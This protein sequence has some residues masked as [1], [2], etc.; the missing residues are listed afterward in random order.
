MCNLILIGSFKVCSKII[1]WIFKALFS[2]QDP[3]TGFRC[4][5]TTTTVSATSDDGS[6]SLTCS[7]TSGICTGSIMEEVTY[8][9]TVGFTSDLPQSLSNPVSDN[10]LITSE[11]LVVIILCTPLTFIIEPYTQRHA[12]FINDCVIV[13]YG[14]AIVYLK[15]IMFNL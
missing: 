14:I 2:P 6:S 9:V 12:R 3:N 1:K 7:N 10:D 5:V 13:R 15:S 11:S 4:P 8:T